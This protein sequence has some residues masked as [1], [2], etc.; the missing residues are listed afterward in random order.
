MP[1]SSDAA[2]TSAS[3]S[4]VTPTHRVGGAP[5]VPG[6]VLRAP[7][8]TSAAADAAQAASKPAMRRGAETTAPIRFSSSVPGTLSRTCSK[9]SQHLPHDSPLELVHVLIERLARHVLE[10]QLVAGCREP[11]TRPRHCPDLRGRSH[12]TGGRWR[13]PPRE[14]ADG[15]RSARRSACRRA[16]G[17]AG[18][19]TPGPRPP[20]RCWPGAWSGSWTGTGSWVS[21]PV[22]GPRRGW[23]TSFLRT[24]ATSGSHVLVAALRDAALADADPHG[25]VP[26]ACQRTGVVVGA[27]PARRHRTRLVARRRLRSQLTTGWA[28]PAIAGTSPSASPLRCR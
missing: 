11:T 2:E 18:S 1:R 10:D 6:V 22:R 15:Y 7:T 12:F 27:P 20:R 25:A 8:A 5:T 9:P 24:R 17:R 23:T 4:R 14:V 28:W 19:P 3:P 13:R 21:C 16:V 26:P